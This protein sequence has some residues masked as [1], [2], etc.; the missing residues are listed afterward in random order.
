MINP[1]QQLRRW[2]QV[3][4]Q[5]RETPLDGEVP[6]WV[7]SFLFHLVLLV[8]LAR[9]FVPGLKKP[10]VDLVL[11]EVD[12]A[13]EEI[14]VA[15]QIQ[16]ADQPVE[17]IGAD[18]V[19]G[20]DLQL[21]QA[22]ILQ[23]T[24]LVEDEP[25]LNIRELGD[26]L[27]QEL[28]ETS[29]APKIESLPVHG[30]VGVAQTG[31]EGAVD[32]ITQEILLSMQER[33]TT[34]VWMFDQSASLLRQRDLILDR[35]D[36]VYQELGVLEERGREEF[37]RRESGKA[38]LL[39]Q[40][41]GFGEQFAAGFKE[42][43][44]DVEQIKSKVR[45]L[46]TD[47]SGIENVFQ[48][49][50][51][52]A[53]DFKAD[54]K[55]IPST[56][57]RR[58]NVMFIVVSDEAGD[59]T[60]ALDDAVAA[61]KRYEI[62]VYV[63]GVPAPFGRKETFVKWVDPDPSFD[64]TPQWAPVSQ[65]PESLFPERLRLNFSGQAFEEESQLDS[66][67]GPYGLTR[68]CYETGGIYFNVH[69]NRQLNRRVRRR[70]TDD[71]TAYFARFF[72]PNIMR[73]Y[74]PDYVTVETYVRR[75]QENRCRFALVQAAEQSWLNPM[76]PPEMRFEKLDEARF[77]NTVSEAQRAAAVLEPKIERLYQILVSG[78]QDRPEEISL[79]WKAGYDL[80]MG[81]VLAVKIRAKT[82]NAMLA[83]AKTKLKFEDPKNN[84][85]ILRPA[86][87][88]STGSQDQKMAE[89]ARTYLQR[90]LDEHPGTPWAFLAQRELETPMGWRWAETYTEPPRPQ[91]NR[92]GNNNNNNVRRMQ[93]ERAVELEPPK[94]KRK[95][96]KL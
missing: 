77:V 63:I 32:R 29:V 57:Q 12:P 41:Y 75:M 49:I 94:P 48:T 39:T 42:P 36:R 23:D 31:A 89:Q 14:E 58:R 85:W 30:S 96:P 82:Y 59:D 35:F 27:V 91:Q 72:D 79:R 8:A 68:L 40:V 87:T 52:A 22:A 84:T 44:A 69:P 37:N 11:A 50:V 51:T 76:E 34:V 54:R 64:Q 53:D 38:P 83:L 55:V 16:F 18:S 17:D 81:R 2:W 13:E 20:A 95:A 9:V 62:P 24:S 74:R 7:L 80:A 47:R 1:L 66:G 56:G 86:E 60:Q 90:V 28:I 10:E 93:P 33:E 5:T 61:C 19:D 45:E 3:Q 25:E 88:V 78:E 4:A 70:Q 67:F 15:P 46:Q 43:V 73:K 65:G 21:S 6:F 26:F 92:P 71:Y